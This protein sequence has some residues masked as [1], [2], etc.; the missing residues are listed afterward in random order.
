HASDFQH[1]HRN[2]RSL[3]L[4]LKSLAGREV[5]LRLVDTA[6]VLVENMRPPVKERLGFDF[7][8]VHARNP[9]L[10]YASLSGFGQD[11]P[12]GD[13][14]GVD[15]IAQGMGGLMSVTGLPGTGPT[16]AGIPVSDLAAG[17]YLA[18]GVL[19]ALHDRD[20]T[21]TGRWVQTSLLE[22]MIAMMDFQATRWTIDRQVPGQAGNHHP[23]SVPMGCFATADGYVNIGA[24]DGR[25]LHAFCS[26]IGLPW[27]PGDPRFDSL[28]KRSANRAELNAL[29]AGQLRTRTTAAWV[30]A[31]NEAGVPCGPVYQMDEVFA[32]PQV[33]HLAMTQTVQHPVLGPLA[34]VRNA[35]RITG[36]PDTVRTPAPDRGDH[37]DEVLTGLGYSPAEIG[38]LR[39]QEVI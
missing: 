36:G 10:V 11:G 37:T 5:L 1:L 35:V 17:L 29:V 18:I 33:E 3:S 24:A 32:D 7:G 2:K 6:D 20:R 38:R 9:R 28:E 4:N 39:A 26:V 12:Y 13:R 34:I 8:T 30:S 25:L 23:T 21:G 19:V 31:L 22:S 27:L 16:R 14:G 15:Q